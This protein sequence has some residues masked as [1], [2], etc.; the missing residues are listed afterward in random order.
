MDIEKLIEDFVV[1]GYVIFNV[2]EDP[3][4]NQVNL[5]IESLLKSGMYK[6]N[7]RI[8]EYNEYPRIVESWKHSQSCLKLSLNDRCVNFLIAL[9]RGQPLAF[10][11]IN[12][13]HST[14][15][16]LHSDLVHFGFRPANMLVGAWIALQDIDPRSGPLCVV[17]GSHGWEIFEYERLGMNP[18]TTLSEA[19]RMYQAYEGWIEEKIEKEG[20]QPLEL[21]LSKGDCI[22]WDA[23]L[24]HG[25]PNCLDNSL[26][27]K[28]QVTHFTFDQH[29]YCYN[30]V[31]SKPSDNFFV[32][33]K[34]EYIQND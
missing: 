17:P 9:G 3:L 28:S 13:L 30:P 5:D 27:R 11:T 1:D 21:N 18:P 12:F 2:D 34:L 15:Q 29:D 31:F 20:V 23:N 8:Y 22:I 32:K 4:I 24:L 10:S 26:H 25:S 19:K 6:K 14:E 33:R 7:S 16:P